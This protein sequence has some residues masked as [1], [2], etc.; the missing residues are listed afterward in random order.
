MKGIFIL[1]LLACSMG[2]S[3]AYGQ[4]VNFKDGYRKANPVDPNSA[5]SVEEAIKIHQHFLDQAT[6]PQDDEKR[7]YGFI[8]LYNDYLK[9]NNYTEAAQYL[10]EAERITE[11]SGNPGWKGWVSHRKGILYVY[12]KNYRGALSCYEA[13][14]DLCGQAHDSL[15]LA[16]SIEQLGATS[17]RLGDYQQAHQYYRLALPLIQQYGSEIQMATTLNNFANLLLEQDSL[18]DAVS[19]YERALVLIR[20]IG[21]TKDETIYLN[22]LASA[23]NHLRQFNI[24]LK[25]LHQCVDINLK[26]GWLHSVIDNYAGLSH[27]YEGINDFRSALD[28]SQRSYALKDSLIGVETQEKITSVERKFQSQQRELAQQKSQIALDAAHRSLERG[29][30]AL[31][32]LSVLTAFII[33]RWKM[34]IHLTLRERKLNQ[35]S[36]QELTRVLLEK[37]A[38]LINLEERT[39]EYYTSNDL[40]I[41][42]GEF[43]ENLYNQR[44]LTDADWTA[45]KSYFEKAYPGYMLRLRTSFPALSDAEKRLFLFIKLNLTTREAAAILGIS[46]D[47]V[48]K[49][50]NRLRKRLELGEETEL[51]AFIRAF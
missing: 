23:Y 16:E 29:I 39:M 15:C 4:V 20:K 2:A 49:T 31:L 51:E 44:I 45:F 9:A 22:N 37:N 6:H 25:I 10:V 24:A 46:A 34:Q 48:K 7:L 42:P 5:I 14:R 30:V 19:Y 13:A 26:N 33:W 3:P 35:E 38:L 50:R 47:S 40:S 43:E 36:L 17:S 27:G 41:N 21:N 8:Y 32:F 12:L 28:Y 18:I 1:L 11:A